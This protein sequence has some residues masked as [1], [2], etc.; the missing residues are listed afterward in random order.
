MSRLSQ[1]AK[2]IKE[3]RARVNAR[4]EWRYAEYWGDRSELKAGVNFLAHPVAPSCVAYDPVTGVAVEVQPIGTSV[5]PPRAD[6][7]REARK[8]LEEWNEQ[9]KKA[10]VHRAERERRVCRAG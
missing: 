1:H 10:A 3:Q 2:N 9:K 8:A 6:Y 5:A 7:E 4:S